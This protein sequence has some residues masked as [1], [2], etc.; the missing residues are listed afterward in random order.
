MPSCSP[1]VVFALNG[2]DAEQSDPDRIFSGTNPHC[3]SCRLL[4][5]FVIGYVRGGG[6]V[7]PMAKFIIAICYLAFYRNKK[8]CGGII[9]QEKVMTRN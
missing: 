7:E 5:K 8:V 1:Q 9:N 3:N 2:S 6:P 4:S